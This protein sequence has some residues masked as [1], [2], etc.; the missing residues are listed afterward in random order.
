MFIDGVL[1]PREKH[2]D[3]AKDFEAASEALSVRPCFHRLALAERLATWQRYTHDVTHGVA[4]PG[5][6]K[7]PPVPPAGPPPP[8]PLPPGG[9]MERSHAPHSGRGGPR[10]H[11]ERPLEVAGRPV[12]EADA[13]RR[14]RESVGRPRREADGGGG[15]R[16]LGGQPPERRERERGAAY[17]VGGRT[18]REGHGRE[19]FRGRD[20]G[21]NG[22]QEYKRPRR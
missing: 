4:N 20:R 9:Q 2:G 12:R 11:G 21:S 22:E 1:Q 18:R 8:G 15:P 5:A 6:P 7:P 3:A 19:D 10:M 14:P 16:E 13:G 17:A